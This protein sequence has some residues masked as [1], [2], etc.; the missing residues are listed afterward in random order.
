MSRNFNPPIEVV[1]KIATYKILER[2]GKGG[3]AEVYKCI[4]E[5]KG[6]EY[7][8]KFQIKQYGNRIDR[9]NK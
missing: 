9:F 8:I 5:T 4:D 6:N 3:N 1:T 7:A 2:L